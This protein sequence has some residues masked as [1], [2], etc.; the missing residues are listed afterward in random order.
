MPALSYKYRIEPNEAQA[1]A[2]EALN[3]VPQ[4]S[5]FAHWPDQAQ[6]RPICAADLQPAHRARCR[7]PS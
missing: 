1:G 5:R 6:S 4:V 7:P 2:L 3:S